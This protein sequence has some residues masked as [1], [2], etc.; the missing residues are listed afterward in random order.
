VKL[1]LTIDSHIRRVTDLSHAI[2]RCAP[3]DSTVFNLNV[4]DIYMTD[5]VTVK[6]HI[7]TN[8]EPVEKNKVD[9]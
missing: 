2:G 6:S 9:I 3:V 8:D 4:T 1:E 7:L 5:Y